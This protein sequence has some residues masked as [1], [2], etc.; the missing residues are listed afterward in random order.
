MIGQDFPKI[1]W[2]FLGLDLLEPNAIIGDRYGLLLPYKYAQIVI[3]FTA[4]GVNSFCG[5]AGVFYSADSATFC[6]ITSDSGVNI[7]HG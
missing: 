2:H 7:L 4:T 3:H 6:T 1:E 5:L